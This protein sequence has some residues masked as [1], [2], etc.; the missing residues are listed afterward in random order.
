MPSHS[1]RH[2]AHLLLHNPTGKHP[3]TAWLNR[4]LVALILVNTAAV[5]M[6]TVQSI[7]QGNE[8]SFRIFE[9]VS[10]AIFLMEYL[11]RLWCSVEQAAYS[12][13]V[14]GRL[15]WATRPVALLDL[16]VI[17]TFFARV[18]L[19]FLRLA[20]LFR[21]LRVLNLDSMAKT[22]ENLKASIAARKDL[23]LVSAVLMFIALFSSAA[24]LYIFEH[25]AQPNLF[26]SIPATLWW[27][28]VT[29]ATIGYG[30]MYPV[31]VAGKLCASFIAVFGVGVFALPTAILTGAV[32]EASA[33]AKV[34]PHCGKPSR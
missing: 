19:R 16:I 29:L 25:E 12:E 7:Y 33:G 24:L 32:I 17:A 11:A 9:T 4:F 22:Y 6:E 2:A 30:D 34:C 15:R 21:L 27:A 23:L 31:T 28:V 20:R 3:L 5:A 10:T 14:L 1:L 18:D 26:S 13:P 8:R